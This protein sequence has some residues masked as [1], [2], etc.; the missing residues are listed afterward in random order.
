MVGKVGD[1]KGGS[2]S[3]G[4]R[5]EQCSATGGNHPETSLLDTCLYLEYAYVAMLQKSET[6]R[7]SHIFNIYIYA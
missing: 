4:R 2:G 1:L 3:F 6:P 7:R 5:I